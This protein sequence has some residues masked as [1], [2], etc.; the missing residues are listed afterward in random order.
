MR[1]HLLVVHYQLIFS[2]KSFKSN[3]ISSKSSFFCPTQVSI[4]KQL[5]R[6]HYFDSLNFVFSMVFDAMTNVIVAKTIHKYIYIYG[7]ISKSIFIVD[8]QDIVEVM[9]AYNVR[10]L[11]QYNNR[12]MLLIVLVS[13]IDL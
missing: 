3:Q 11:N 2:Y 12:I 8:I 13:H 10:L 1:D 7:F 6:R 9:F 5:D 4:R